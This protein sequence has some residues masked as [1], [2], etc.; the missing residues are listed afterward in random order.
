MGASVRRRTHRFSL[1]I[2][3][4]LRT[5][6]CCQTR[7]QLYVIILFVFSVSH[8]HGNGN[9]HSPGDGGGGGEITLVCEIE[10]TVIMH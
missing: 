2:F 9:C 3:H 7:L 10:T 6:R 1:G 5:I 4:Y 8:P